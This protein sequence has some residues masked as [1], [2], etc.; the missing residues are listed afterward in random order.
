MRMRVR[1]DIRTPNFISIKSILV[2]TVRRQA[3]FELFNA[4]RTVF[5]PL[6]DVSH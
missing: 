2:V 5:W 1:V 3:V 6:S 4:R